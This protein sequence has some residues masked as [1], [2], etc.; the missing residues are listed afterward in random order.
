[1]TSKIYG[2]REKRLLKFLVT[3]ED[4]K[5]VVSYHIDP[6]DKFQRGGGGRNMTPP[7]IKTR[8]GKQ[9][10]IWGNESGFYSLFSSS[11]LNQLKNSKD[12]LHVL[13][14]HLSGNMSNTNYLITQIT[15]CL[16]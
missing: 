7:I 3:D 15:T 11:N 14:S 12:G 2:S 6:E 10:V 4:P 5:R 9:K 1:M 13:C 16:K 8:G